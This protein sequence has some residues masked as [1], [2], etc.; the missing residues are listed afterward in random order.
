MIADK[1]KQE[2]L[3]I[4]MEECAELQVEA[5]KIIRFGS[6]TAENIHKLEVEIGDLMC[7]IDLLDQ[8]K[9]I[10]LG[11]VA[12]HKAAKREKLKLWSDLIDL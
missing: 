8:Y 10:D 2:A 4:T 11:E 7:M 1:V 3:T 6:D 9:L 5:A 12:E